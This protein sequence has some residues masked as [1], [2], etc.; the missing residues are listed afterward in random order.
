MTK[1]F[2]HLRAHSEFSV[3]ESIYRIDEMIDKAKIDGQPAVAMTDLDGLFGAI[4]FYEKAREGGVK[5]I[6][7]VDIQTALTPPTAP[8]DAEG[9]PIAPNPLE[10]D[11]RRLVLLA[12]DYQGY[13]KLM[14]L[15]TRAYTY[16][17]IDNK[18]VIKEE[19]LREEG[20]SGVYCLSGTE[21]GHIGAPLLKGDLVLASEN[22]SRLKNIFGDNLFIEVQRRGAVTDGAFVDGSVKIADEL[23]LPLVATHPIQFANKNDFVAHELKVCDA[24]KEI[25]PDRN[26]ERTFTPHQHFLTTQEMSVLFS[27]LPDAIANAS[28]I[29]ESCS[30][31]IPIG[32][33]ELPDFQTGTDESL[34]QF[35]TRVS[36]EGLD[37]RLAKLY[38]NENT[39][40]AKRPEY[41]KRLDHEINQIKKMGFEGYFMIVYDFINWA[42][43][44]EIPVGPGRGSGA[45]SLVAYSLGITD[46]DPLQYNLLFERFLNPERV[47]MPDFD[48]DFCVE[49]RE[50]VIDYVTRK[51]GSDAVAGITAIG[52]LASRAA[53][54]A[55][56]RALGMNH[57]MVSGVSKLI[58][59]KPGQ[60]MSIEIAMETVQELQERYDSESEVKKLLDHA[61]T[62]EGLPKSVGRHAAGVVIARG[63]IADYA[64]I[65]V[66]SAIQRTEGEDDN[67]ATAAGNTK[68]TTQYDKDDLEKV[69]LV[70]FDFLGLKNLTMID[71]AIRTIK[72]QPG[73]ENFDIST[74]PLDAPDVYKMFQRGDTQA[75]FQFESDFMRKILLDAQ[76]AKLDDLIALNALG[77]PGPMDLIPEYVRNKAAPA[78]ITYQDPRMKS[79]LDETYG[80]MVY[81]EQVMQ[82]AQTIGGYT[83]GGAD[84]LRRAM[85]KKKIEEMAKHRQIFADGAQKNGLSSTDANKIFSDMEKFAG[86]GFNKSHA[87]AYSVVAYQTAYLKIKHP[88][89]FFAAVLSVDSVEDIDKVPGLIADA[90][91][92]GLTILPPDIN[93]SVSGFIIDANQPKAIR[94]GLAG[95]KGIGIEAVQQI[96]NART[97]HGSF[98]S[99]EDFM[100]KCAKCVPQMGVNLVNKTVAERL[101]MAGCFDEMH[102]NRSESIAAYPLINKYNTDVTKRNAKLENRKT[103]NALDDLFALSGVDPSAKKKSKP[104]A[105][106]KPVAEIERYEWPTLPKQPL[107]ELLE[108]EKKAFGF[109]F[110]GHPMTYYRSQLGE[111]KATESIAELSDAYPS[112]DDLHLVAG[113]VSD[114]KTFDT[115]NGKMAK[116]NISD[117]KDSIEFVAF[118]D[119]YSS[120][121]D[122]LK[123]DAFGLFTFQVKEDKFK[124]GG[125]S[126]AAQSI[127]NFGEAQMFLAH[128]VHISIDFEDVQKLKDI[129]HQNPGTTPI[130][131]WH[132][133]NG[134]HAPSK[135]APLTI[136]LTAALLDQLKQDF[137]K[138]VKLGFPKNKMVVKAPPRQKKWR[139]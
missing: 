114:I 31:A 111:L 121:K 25:L 105:P 99:L 77:R 93:K 88:D 44:H 119:T 1:P 3:V 120:V 60:K 106:P 14:R 91:S 52:K 58:P 117:G 97:L 67:A 118:A 125:N 30:L 102:P 45:G 20:P 65:Y 36:Y 2:T 84:L 94:Y 47:S 19:W 100:S 46:L 130:T 69:G 59:A 87:A 6:I 43:Q 33:P 122:W 132:P 109:Y 29:A 139:N 40:G 8:L 136:E 98:D 92:K 57:M 16:N 124:G 127:R 82:I 135:D 80:I 115:K 89:A 9:N 76:P 4:R 133:I 18:P 38:P 26:R 96:L 21:A 51:Y 72:S 103:D 54:G 113:V 73:N 62:L 13:L 95:L 15:I 34:D 56:G 90:Q 70:K 32:K 11:P 129:V 123:K 5:P 83:L 137:G 134:T 112:F 128:T 10:Q 116:G 71:K 28:V 85:G 41:V 64:P 27:D 35:F 126:Y 24:R 107:M 12:K 101:I 138:N 66:P 78:M 68:L 81:Q 55:A 75:V 22:A 48:I 110:S 61:I 131:L 63:R 53:V 108:N 39:K 50:L 79:I 7:G 37:K 23:A 17:L 74:I 42:H 49:R 104:K 86:Y